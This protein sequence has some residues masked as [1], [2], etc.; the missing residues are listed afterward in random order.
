VAPRACQLTANSLSQ[1]IIPACAG[2]SDAVLRFRVA[3]PRINP[4]AAPDQARLSD[5][6]LVLAREYGFASWQKLKRHVEGLQT[7][8]GPVAKLAA[9]FARW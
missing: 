5:A 6:Q 8:P 3:H 7:M 2:D 1:R 4:S 9:R